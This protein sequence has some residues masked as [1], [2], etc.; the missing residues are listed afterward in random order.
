MPSTQY[1][2]KP[3]AVWFRSKLAVFAD[4]TFIGLTFDM[5]KL[6]NIPIDITKVKDSWFAK[7]NLK[8]T[9]MP[10]LYLAPK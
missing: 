10:G 8:A 3:V 4:Y 1:K 7:K 9:V 2:L 6:K 5:M